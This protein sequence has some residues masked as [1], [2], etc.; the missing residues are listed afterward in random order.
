VAVMSAEAKIDVA[1][2]EQKWCETTVDHAAAV[3]AAELATTST[4]GVTIGR[5]LTDDHG[6]HR[7]L[8]SRCTCAYR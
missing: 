1:V 5:G 2:V 6:R 8:G 7:L 3:A 4:V